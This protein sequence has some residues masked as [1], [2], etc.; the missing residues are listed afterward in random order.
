MRL[1]K[2][3]LIGLG[4][5]LVLLIGAAFVVVSTLDLNAYRGEI[6][7]R[8]QQATGRK[9]ELRGKIDA[10]FLSAS[11]SVIVRDVGLSNATWG[12]RA[13]MAKFE[14]LEM[15]VELWPLISGVLKINKLVLVGADVF[16]ETNA[17]GAK[18]WVF[19][20]AVP[21]PLTTNTPPMP[22]ADPSRNS[23]L[24]PQ[25]VE[26][27]VEKSTFTYHDAV[28][29]STQSIGLKEIVLRPSANDNKVAI[30]IEGEYNGQKI[31]TKGTIGSLESLSARTDKYPMKLD[32]GFA[33]SDLAV[34]LIADLSGAVTRMTGMVA[35]KRLALDKLA[36]APPKTP[37]PQGGILP[38]HPLPLSALRIANV[39]LDLKIDELTTGGRKFANV[40]GKIVI[41]DA[42]LSLAPLSAMLG[43]G[44]ITANLVVDGTEGI[45]ASVIGK[46]TGRNL[47]LR[48]LTPVA[49]APAS[50][51]ADVAGRGGSIKAI[52]ST[53]NGRIAVNVGPGPINNQL[54]D[55][56]SKGLVNAV[57]PWAPRGQALALT[58]IVARFD[59]V[60]GVGRSRVLVID[61]NRATLV[62]DGVVNLAREAVDILIVPST[63]EK[64][65][66]SVA[67]LIPVRVQGPI[68][69][70][71]ITPDPSQAAQEAAKTVIKVA[72]IPLDIVGN[73]LGER[74]QQQASPCGVANARATGQVTPGQQQPR[75]QQQ[76][77]ILQRINPLR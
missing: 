10:T 58:C 1:F 24:Q 47:A 30:E 74:R 56:M 41:K 55:F 34:E 67:A 6:A 27:R 4:A 66:A 23:G 36:G 51:D 12:T 77:G 69:A 28:T 18:N 45:Q 71:S 35:S 42:K 70:V 64:S 13:D 52:A 38:I 25:I 62:G 22:T 17:Q 2:K 32:I 9:F 11:P 19:V 29:K 76:P 14:R 8:V 43:A 44:T 57:T 15:E 7:D 21:R 20:P 65:L 16:L 40:Q 37:A 46:L 61:T 5:V 49:S 39:D 33:D 72:E 68:N 53:L 73:L 59:F 60:S 31:S 63:K 3:I 54:F 26:L 75:Q 48:D 50:F